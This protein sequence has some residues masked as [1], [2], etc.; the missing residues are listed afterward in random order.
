M[1]KFFRPVSDIEGIGPEYAARLKAQ[2]VESLYQLFFVKPVSLRRIDK[3][4]PLARLRAWRSAA[5]LLTID[6]VSPDIAECLV[7][8]GVDTV[9]KLAKAG[10]QS[11]ERAIKEGVET[12]KIADPPSIYKLAEIQ[13]MALTRADASVVAGTWAFRFEGSRHG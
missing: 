6:N 12:G 7:A 4:L 2:Q 13:R 5:W 1:N 8:E 9:G 11:L 3:T 10:L